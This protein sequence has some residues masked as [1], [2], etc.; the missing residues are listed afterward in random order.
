M[1]DYP[2]FYVPVGMALLRQFSDKIVL[3]KS[4]PPYESYF[5]LP[6]P[7]TMWR[8]SV[9]LKKDFDKKYVSDLAVKAGLNPKYFMYFPAGHVLYGGVVCALKERE[10]YWCMAT[11]CGNCFRKFLGMPSVQENSQCASP[12]CANN[13]SFRKRFLLMG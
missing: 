3:D 11:H 9:H 1:R 8:L 5:D 2:F 6:V 13:E 7:E 12:N 4:T 10:G